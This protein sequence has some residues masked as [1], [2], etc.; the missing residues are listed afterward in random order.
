MA[1]ETELLGKMQVEVEATL[2]R[3]SKGLD[4]AR[5]MAEDG[6]KK[7]ER[8]FQKTA[9]QIDKNNRSA[10]KSFG[11]IDAAILNNVKSTND[12]I[13]VNDKLFLE[14]SKKTGKVISTYRVL[15]GVIE[16]NI[17]GNVQG[18]QKVA[19]VGET[20]LNRTARSVNVFGNASKNCSIAGG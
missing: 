11:A 19:N 12:L 15:N 17:R 13:Q 1:G 3:F 7:I 2:E 8:Q 14:V 20:A 9:E 6:A 16:Q 10:E 4:D 18:W 5:K